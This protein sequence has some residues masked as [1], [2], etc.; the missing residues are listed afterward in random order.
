M[1][2]RLLTLPKNNSF[3]LFGAR[4]TGKSTLIDA[5][6]DPQTTLKI[7]L[8]HDDEYEKYSKRPSTIRDEVEA[9]EALLTHVFIDEIQK[10][11]AL[12]DEVQSLIYNYKKRIS[13]CMSGS[14]ARKLKRAGANL[15]AGRAWTFNLF[16][17]THIELGKKFSLEK[18]LRYGSLPSVAFLESEQ[19][20]SRNL[21]SYV[22]TYLKEEIQ[23]ETEIRNFGAF[24]RFLDIAADL[25]GQLLNFSDVGRDAGISYATAKGYFQIL[26]DTLLG[27]FLY[28]YSGKISKRIKR[29]P[30]FYLFDLGVKRAIEKKLSIAVNPRTTEYGQAF[31]HFLINE[32]IHLARYKE[33]DYDFSF[34]RTSNDAEVDLIVKKPDGQVY[35]IEIKS[36]DNPGPGSFNGL[37]SFK[38]VV[39]KANLICACNAN[40]DQK[41]GDVLVL[42]WRE[43]IK[44]LG[45][46]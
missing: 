21:R 18:V 29:A 6:L 46:N 31:E 38:D 19:D 33:L 16:P 1:I 15:L 23:R 3:F 36:G 32:I 20:I 34:Y 39:P 5:L 9:K 22:E 13:F 35:A 7:D 25:N 40:R 43:A 12:L 8:L 24:L 10:V 27:Q 17:L 11:P 30:K 41:R 45:L 37:I 28:A 4:Q 14:S 26:E 44:L 2:N 42:P